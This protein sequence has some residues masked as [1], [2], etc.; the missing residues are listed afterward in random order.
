MN[1]QQIE[2]FRAAQRLHVSQPG[3][4]HMLA[5][6]ELQLG[7][8]L[9]ER[10][11][12]KL[13]PTPEAQ[14]L[15]AEVEQVYSGVKRIEDC[16]RALKSGACLTLRVLASPST[17]LEV[18]PQAVLGMA[19]QYPAARIYLETLPAREMVNQLVNH[20]ADVAISTLPIAHVLLVSKVIGKWRLACVF[21]KGHAL[22]KLRNPGMRD[23][24]KERLIAFSSDTP[25]GLAIRQWCQAHAVESVSSIEVRA[26]HTACALVVCGAGVAIVD[27][28]TARA[29]SGDKLG[30]RP[31]LKG[32]SF[33]L[34]AVTNPNFATSALAAAFVGHATATLKQLRRT[35][36]LQQQ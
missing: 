36:G 21:P 8:Q 10:K 35:N 26:G 11:K 31:L 22:E 28:L 18:A 5:H 2:V 4:S 23:I 1:L 30:F 16:A 12:G 13:H 7:M 27:D 25:Q 33:D 24:L 34:F 19:R 20:D 32:P 6:V 3:I 17:A 15:Y 29:Y 9:L 14:A